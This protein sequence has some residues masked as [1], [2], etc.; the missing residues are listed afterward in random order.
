MSESR[1]CPQ[2]GAE[3][4][5]DGPDAPCP[6]CLIKLGLDSWADRADGDPE[7]DAAATDAI[8]GRFQPPDPEELAEHFPQLEILELLGVGGM[9]AVYKARQ[10]GLERLVALKI[11][12]PEVGRDPAFAEHMAH[13]HRRALGIVLTIRQNNHADTLFFALH[14]RVDRVAQVCQIPHLSERE[15]VGESSRRLLSGAALPPQRLDVTVRHRD[16]LD[17]LLL[18]DLAQNAGVLI[19]QQAPH[20][21]ARLIHTPMIGIWA[22][23]CPSAR[24]APWPGGYLA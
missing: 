19:Q 23:T 3:L 5:S 15:L 11:L 8:P 10:P 22:T 20:A 13:L 12:P 24:N 21:R 6:A 16:Q 4:P 14:H 17:V 9:G 7:Q 2:C 1:R 18:R